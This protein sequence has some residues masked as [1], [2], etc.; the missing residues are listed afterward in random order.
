MILINRNIQVLRGVSV[1]FVVF[2]H[3]ESPYFKF[4]YLG[5]DVFFL[6]S[7]FLIP[8]IIHKYNA[9]TFFKARVKRL[10]PALSIIVLITIIF[11]YFIN[12][13]GE[14]YNISESALYSLFFISPFYFLNNT[15]YFD[16]NSL[17]QPLLHTW[18]LGNEFFAY[19]IV[20][21]F[22]ILGRGKYLRILSDLTASILFIVFTFLLYKG[23]VD[24]LNPIPRMFLFFLAFSVS[25]RFNL[26]KK[27]IP[28]NKN[29][30]IISIISLCILIFFF[31]DDISSH[32]WPSISIFL[33]PSTVIPLMLIRCDIIPINKLQDYFI[34][35]GDYSYAVY[36]V[37]WPVIVFERTY[38]RNLNISLNETFILLIIIIISSWTLRRFFEKY[39]AKTKYIYILAIASCIFVFENEGIKDRVPKGFVKYSSLE[40]MTN[41]KFYLERV[42]YTKFNYDVVSESNKNYGILVIGDSHSQHIIPI[43]KSS[44]LGNIYRIRLDE[45]DLNENIEEV[46]K[47]IELKGITQV[48]VAYRI[49]T[50]NPNMLISSIKGLNSQKKAHI[51]VMRDI[52]SFKGDPVACLL[53]QESKLLF[54][55]CDFNII[56]GIPFNGILNY[57]DPVWSKVSMMASNNSISFIDSHGYLCGK[58]CS[59]FINNEL[60]MRD[61]NHLNER[62]SNETNEILFNLLLKDAL[63]NKK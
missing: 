13:P 62:L 23:E 24:Y 17:L 1:L 51:Y 27:N 43:I 60:I 2:F 42:Q 45:Y 50:K 63:Q 35:L 39:E 5:V 7:G 25:F 18:S 55:G 15:G 38:F 54:K 33:L 4:G 9:I 48:L 8:I 20:S 34:K 3:L 11:G 6:I 32:L 28:S 26:D 47:F 57:S 59:V 40:K 10:A 37:H 31:K 14:Y 16:Q 58:K 61:S 56:K 36:L 49:S 29:L 53:S 52:P 41:E 22:L 46:L 19:I 44:F 21:F 30:S 12:M